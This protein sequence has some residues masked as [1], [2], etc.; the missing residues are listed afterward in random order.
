MKV[1]ERIAILAQDG[2][3]APRVV[4]PRAAFGLAAQLGGLLRNGH[5]CMCGR[6]RDAQNMPKNTQ[7]A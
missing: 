2:V 6:T 7:T 5:V 4:E 3:L 1:Q